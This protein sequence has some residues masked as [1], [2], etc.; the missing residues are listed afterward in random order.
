M[1]IIAWNNNIG[2]WRD[3]LLAALFRRLADKDKDKDKSP[4]DDKK[5]LAP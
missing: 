1:S 3:A 5:S 2:E 4:A